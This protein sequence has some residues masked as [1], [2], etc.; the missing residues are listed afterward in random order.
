M[1]NEEGYES[2]NVRDLFALIAHKLHHQKRGRGAG[3][4]KILNILSAVEQ[5]NQKDLQDQ[6]EIQAGSLSEILGK[7]EKNEWIIREKSEEDKRS[8][9]IKITEKGREALQLIKEEHKHQK[10]IFSVLNAEE[11]ESLKAILEKLKAQLGDDAHGE[12]P[13]GEYRGRCKHGRLKR[14]LLEAAGHMHARDS[15]PEAHHHSHLH[16]KP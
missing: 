15:H 7:L 2:G 9:V 1:R 13:D 11:E 6:L 5:I 4:G 16:E 14:A 8:A 12:M 10:D 3:Q